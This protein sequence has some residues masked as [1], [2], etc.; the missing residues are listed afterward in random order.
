MFVTCGEDV[1]HVREI[2]TTYQLYLRNQ[3]IVKES[4]SCWYSCVLASVRHSLV[5]VI[6][7]PLFHS[8]K[9]KQFSFPFH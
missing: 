9:G 1:L 4:S 7:F 8:A 6:K 5:F 3:M 2:K